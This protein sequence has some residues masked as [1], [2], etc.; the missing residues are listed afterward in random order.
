MAPIRSDPDIHD[1]RVRDSPTD[2]AAAVRWV[3]GCVPPPKSS[4]RSS[5]VDTSMAA[6]A[7]QGLSRGNPAVTENAGASA[8]RTS[9]GFT[10]WSWTSTELRRTPAN[11]ENETCALAG[12]TRKADR[13]AVLKACP[14][15]T[16][17]RL[18]VSPACPVASYLQSIPLPGH[19]EVQ[20]R[21]EKHADEQLR[22]HSADDDH[23]ERPLRIGA[24]A[25]G[26]GGGEEPERRDE[27]GHHDGAKAKQRGFAGGLR[28]RHPVPPQLVG[29]RD[30]HH[31]GLDRHPEQGQEPDPGGYGERRAGEPE[32]Q[33]SAHRCREQYGGH[34]DQ[35][36]L[37]IAV[38]R[39]EDQKD[40]PQR[41]R[42]DHDHLAPG[43]RVFLELAAPDDMV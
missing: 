8:G 28:D 17:V 18:A 37:E 26:E 30:V 29:V 16:T 22:Q 15:L 24:H 20:C 7:C 9:N 3:I 27:R 42:H 1:L 10:I 25:R 12:D 33:Q 39:E 32:G 14:L 5:L 23:R 13:S 21:Y 11:T 19:E 40:E 31:G 2:T 34:G 36:E 38:Q 35:G 43:R 6:E 4:R 41:H